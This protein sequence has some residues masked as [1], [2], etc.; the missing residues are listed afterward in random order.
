ME[1]RNIVVYKNDTKTRNESMRWKIKILN[2][3]A[4]QNKKILAKRYSVTN[5]LGNSNILIS[6]I[7]SFKKG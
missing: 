2:I 4:N 5:Y 6:R 7:F 3:S 1:L